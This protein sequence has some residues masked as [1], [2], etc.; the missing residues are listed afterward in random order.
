MTTDEEEANYLTFEDAF[1]LVHTRFV[2]NVPE[3][4][5]KRV[6]RLFFHLE[7]AWWYY[8]DLICDVHPEWNLPRFSSLYP[9]ALKM[10]DYS[11]LL[12]APEFPYL[13]TSFTI[14]RSNRANYGCILMNSDCSKFLL[15]RVWN[16]DSYTFPSG[17]IS[18]GEAGNVAAA[19]EA[20]EETGFDPTAQQGMTAE[21]LQ[22]DHSKI[23]WNKTL[24]KSNAL[25]VKD[26]NGKRRTLYVVVGVPEDF[27]F[28]PV[29]SKEV[30]SVAWFPVNRVPKDTFAVASFLGP[31]R[32]WIRI[33]KK[34][35]ISSPPIQRIDDTRPDAPHD[36]LQNATSNTIGSKRQRDLL[37][38][39]EMDDV[40]RAAVAV[41]EDTGCST[42]KE[43]RQKR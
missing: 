8:D 21:W 38:H 16:G 11:P 27:P 28:Q 30:S 23:T 1:E 43:K 9:F 20:Y 2:L 25:T 10:F 40:A 19:R 33:N 29:T 14:Y 26:P 34:R 35:S 7:Q 15:C 18:P 41:L 5:R 22:R 4:E 17:K 39:Q 36:A 3:A 42:P 13:W 31:L 32:K 24:S 6:D 37:E 12:H